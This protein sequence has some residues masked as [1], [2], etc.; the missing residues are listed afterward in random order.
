MSDSPYSKKQNPDIDAVDSIPFSKTIDVVVKKN[1]QCDWTPLRNYHKSII[2]INDFFGE[3]IQLDLIQGILN[4]VI[5]QYPLFWEEI[6]QVAAF[7]NKPPEQL[8]AINLLYD[9]TSGAFGC[10]SFAIN[11]DFGPVHC[12]CLDWELG[13]D[14]LQDNTIL[15]RFFSDEKKL[16]FT[17][18]GWP[19]FLGVYYGM[20]PLKFSI[21]LNAVWSK[22][23]RSSIIPLGLFLRNV[24]L[25][26]PDYIHA[27]KILQ[28]SELFCDCILLIT[29]AL[30][31]EMSIIERTPTCASIIQD[32]PVMATNHFIDLPYG[33]NAP[34]YTQTGE[35]PF[36]IG[37]FE[38]YAEVKT[39]FLK[40][41]ALNT[42]DC[43]SYL[44]KP[45]IINDLT[46][47]RTIFKTYSGELNISSIKNIEL[48]HSNCSH[49][50]SDKAD[51]Q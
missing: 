21:T 38:R 36:G 20:A 46:I 25:Q 26:E 35:E 47:H 32:N 23:K 29:G 48:W 5:N 50:Y 10:T 30:L 9:L 3:Y 12:H 17:S 18:I 16:L 31:G 42:K 8:L 19:G 2:A 40:N 14:I 24:F 33:L 43:Q 41:P 27:L 7:S 13:K 6:K 4:K 45:P 39:S 51:T 11:D 1:G 37:S 22:E 28:K 44:N 49:T 34:D 15:I